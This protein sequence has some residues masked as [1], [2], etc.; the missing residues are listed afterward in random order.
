MIKDKTNY[1]IPC[2]SFPED[3]S[4][5]T[6]ISVRPSGLRPKPPCNAMVGVVHAPNRALVFGGVHDVESEDGETVV[7]YFHN[8]LYSIELDKAKWHLFTYA[9][10]KQTDHNEKKAGMKIRFSTFDIRFSTIFF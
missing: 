8:D 5:V 7:G 9:I 6:S 10:A 1:S 2:L 3:G 4:I